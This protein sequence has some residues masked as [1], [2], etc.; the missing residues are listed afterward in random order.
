MEEEPDGSREAQL[1]NSSS[2]EPLPGRKEGDEADEAESS[3]TGC[4]WRRFRPKILAPFAHVWT[5]I[6][7]YIVFAFTH[8]VQGSYPIAVLTTL[9]RRFN[10]SSVLAAVIVNISVFGYI[11]SIIIFSF[12]LSKVNKPRLF[13]VCMLL[14]SIGAFLYFLPHVVLGTGSE[15]SNAAHAQIFFNNTELSESGSGA[16]IQL[17]GDDARGLEKRT[18]M[19]MRM[20]SEKEKQSADEDVSHVVPAVAILSMADFVHGISAA[21]IWTV[22]LVFIDDHTEPQLSAKLI[23]EI[24]LHI[25]FLG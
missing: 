17:C 4:G 16:M 23:G 24:I 10:L 8:A 6:V 19:E 25:V 1:R 20:C 21:S 7:L 9:E 14:T 2:N 18:E 22:G 11:I 5:F 13:A 12:F 15:A 3:S